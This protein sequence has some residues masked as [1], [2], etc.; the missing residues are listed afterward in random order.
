[1]RWPAIA[2]GLL[3][4]ASAVAQS[5][6]SAEL[7]ARGDRAWESRDRVAAFAAYDALIR[8]DSVAHPVALMRLGTLHGWAGRLR[9]AITCHALFVRTRPDDVEG[10]LALGRS[11][12]WSGRYEAATAQYLTAQRI[13][14]GSRDAPLGRATVA[15]WSGDLDG[16][17]ATLD[18]WGRRFPRDAE[19]RVLRAR[20]LG[21]Q[22]RA[23]SELALHDSLL[24][25]GAALDGDVAESWR[26]VHAD[27]APSASA[28]FTHGD[29]S[30][31][32]R[33]DL[34]EA[35]TRFGARGAWRA[36]VAA[37]GKRV[38]REDLPGATVTSTAGTVALAWQPL[39]TRWTLRGELGVNQSDAPG[40][41][42][43]ALGA[44]RFSSPIG[45]TNSASL[46]ASRSAFDD[47]T[48]SAS[49]GL[50]LDVAEVEWISRVRPS[51]T[52][53]AVGGMG[54]ARGDGA[55]NGRL[56]GSIA[57]RHAPRRGVTLS[58]AHRETAWD[59][60]APGAYF[61]PQRFA[62]TEASAR[63]ETM[64]E[65]G[66]VLSGDVGLGAQV[67]RIEPS[68]AVT[69]PAPRFAGRAGWRAAPGREVILGLSWAATAAAGTLD[70]ADYRA[71]A[72]TLGARWGF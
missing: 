36:E 50:S 33:L 71:R 43:R 37:R 62:L 24:R 41:D 22:G 15:A 49:L 21:W 25:S 55:A 3:L 34:I 9:A 39:P 31:G 12:A 63:W 6:S 66:V 11:L 57:L 48:N 14:P 40:A 52:L 42:A 29:D 67:V 45:S 56:A 7:L 23:T 19:G 2:A 54:A 28:R 30:E 46:T 47:I 4:A 32:N 27:I 18:E 26:W 10:R 16:A 20:F 59:R 60:A 38:S 8:L 68:A 51:L 58:L 1:M 69:N 61:A 5:P 70:V 53:E 13:E 65:L 44:L 64:R 35:G 72:I 17:L